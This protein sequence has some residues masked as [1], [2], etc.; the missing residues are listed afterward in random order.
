MIIT[1]C[2][3]PRFKREFKY[4]E[5]VLSLRRHLVFGGLCLPNGEHSTVWYDKNQRHAILKEVLCWKI[6]LSNAV[7]VVDTHIDEKRASGFVDEAACVM[8]NDLSS[9]ISHA[10]KLHKPVYYLSQFS[11]LEEVVRLQ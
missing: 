3:E 5:E 11:S 9:V 8:S 6:A 4:I 10:E 2:G 1:L 7:M